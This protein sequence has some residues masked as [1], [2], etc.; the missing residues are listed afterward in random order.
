MSISFCIIWNTNLELN[1]R[2]F[3]SRIIAWNL[4][5]S[6]LGALCTGRLAMTCS[7]TGAKPKQ[8]KNKTESWNPVSCAQDNC[9]QPRLNISL[10]LFIASSLLLMFPVKSHCIA[11]GECVYFCP[12][13]S[14]LPK[15]QSMPGFDQEKRNYFPAGFVK[16]VNRLSAAQRGSRW[17]AQRRRPS[18]A[19]LI[20]LSQDR[21][22]HGIS[23]MRIRTN[24]RQETWAV[25]PVLLL[26]LPG[27]LITTLKCCEPYLSHHWPEGLD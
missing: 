20:S 8:A 24:C 12:L 17:G 25:T 19:I 6:V 9:S 21:D 14:I 22:L 4:G 1:L 18:L 13:G 23:T 15:G 3:P 5:T 26:S 16:P 11:L 2:H 10:P 7:G 27:T